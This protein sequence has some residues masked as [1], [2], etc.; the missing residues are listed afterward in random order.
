MEQIKNLT[1]IFLVGYLLPTIVCVAFA[2]LH[3]RDNPFKKGSDA[4]EWVFMPAANVVC[5]IVI[6]YYVCVELTLKAIWK[7]LVKIYKKI[8]KWSKE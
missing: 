3:N 7:R 4:G 6:I 2:F 8:E 1:L 5:A